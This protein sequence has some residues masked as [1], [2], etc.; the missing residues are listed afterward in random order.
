MN[1]NIALKREAIEILRCEGACNT[2]EH[3]SIEK[4]WLHMLHR[5]EEQRRGRK[6]FSHSSRGPVVLG[7][8]EDHEGYGR[9][10]YSMVRG[11][12]YF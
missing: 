5:R 11:L 12:G 4:G 10:H 2:H 1:E 8:D 3:A 9:K 6:K 7:P